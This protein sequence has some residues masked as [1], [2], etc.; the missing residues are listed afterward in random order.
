MLNALLFIGGGGGGFG[1]D[2]LLGGGGGATPFFVIPTK[3]TPF[4]YPFP[5][6]PPF[7]EFLLIES[8]ADQLAFREI[9]VALV[10]GELDRSMEVSHSLSGLLLPMSSPEGSPNTFSTFERPRR[11][12]VWICSCCCP[13]KLGCS[14]GVGRERERVSAVFKRL[15]IGREGEAERSN[16]GSS[17]EGELLPELARD[18]RKGSVG[19]KGMSSESMLIFD[20]K[21]SS[22][23][24]R[25]RSRLFE[26][27][28]L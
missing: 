3:P 26:I 8:N 1:F 24:D 21:R 12:A 18:E 19:G 13:R 5:F 6:I 16:P 15:I 4:P 9:D 2:D 14:I 11:R 7:E 17:R 27:D 23:L 22:V 10:A 20:R 28:S 25:E